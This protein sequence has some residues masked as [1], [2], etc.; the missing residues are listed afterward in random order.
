MTAE[1]L[2]NS[3]T[4]DLNIASVGDQGPALLLLH[5]VI[6]AWQDFASVIP[7]LSARYRVSALDFRGHGR[8][9]WT[10]ERYYVRDY[11]D[12]ALAVL[13]Q[14]TASPAVVYGHSLGA[15]VAMALAT[16]A[17]HLV[18]ALILEDPPFETMGSRLLVTPLLD[19]F[20]QLQSLALRRLE[21]PELSAAMAEIRMPLP[22]W[23]STVRLGDLR[24]ATTL[25]FGAECLAQADPEVLKPIVD[26]VWLR[27]YDTR[28]LFRQITCPVLLL[29]GN[30][31]LG[32]MLTDDDAAELEALS[33]CTRVRFSEIGHHIH[34]QQPEV[35][36]RVVFDFIESLPDITLHNSAATSR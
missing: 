29:Q 27:G 30:S 23:T 16:R 9:M 6:R 28:G 17:P 14:T 32:G 20:A 10:P 33:R 18:R 24:D 3:A 31:A 19:Y 7:A 26:G 22:G 35:T 8:S 25:R 11:V 15:M 1:R 12:D 21:V 36:V 5:G 13:S 2:L 4:G 34:R